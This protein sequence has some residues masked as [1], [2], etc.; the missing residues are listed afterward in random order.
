MKNRNH[1]EICNMKQDIGIFFWLG[2]FDRQL[3]KKCIIDSSIYILAGI[4]AYKR[5]WILFFAKSEKNV[6]VSIPYKN[7]IR[8]KEL[9][10]NEEFPVVEANDGDL[11]MINIE[12]GEYNENIYV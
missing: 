11:V 5:E 4:K 2:W 3:L 1:S 8:F 6:T 9:F 12:D 7:N 10:S